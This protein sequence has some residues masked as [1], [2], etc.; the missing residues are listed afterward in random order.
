MKNQGPSDIY[1]KNKLAL[2][3]K[4]H[5]LPAHASQANQDVAEAVKA[6]RC[7]FLAAQPILGKLPLRESNARSYSRKFPFVPVKGKGIVLTDVEGRNY[8]DCLGVAGTLALGYDN[9]IIKDALREFLD[10]GAPLQ[11]LDLAT[12]QKD[13]FMTELL[14]VL[15]KELERLQFCGPAGTDALE[16]AVKIC[17]TKTG[18]S[19]VLS[20]H[21]GYHG[22][23]QGSL[24]MMGNLA[25]KSPI[26]GLMP[27]VHFLPY[28]YSYRN[29]FCIQ[30]EAGEKAVMAYIRTVLTDVESGIP[31]PACVVVEAIQGEGGVNEMSDWALQELRRITKEQDVPLII[32]EVQAGFCRSGHFW[33]FQRSGIVP[34]VLCMSKAVGGGLPQAIVAFRREMDVWS[35]GGHA[36]TF[37]GNQL[38]FV[39]ATAEIK[40]MKEQKLWEKVAKKG[41]HLLAILNK[42]KEE[43]PAIGCVRGRGLMVGVELVNPDAEKDRWGLQPAWGALAAQAQAECFSRGLIIERGGRS[44]CVMRFLVPLIVTEQ[45]LDECVKI[46]GEAIKAA[47]NMLKTSSK[48]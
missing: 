15:P 39:A 42:L 4:G 20:F 34:D 19:T 6:K 33:A 43:Q 3:A 46:F 27:Y 10:S 22:H 16:A 41:E 17:K 2:E 40:Y 11:V 38:A 23:G 31:K 29:P 44:G 9:P 13:A 35:P 45:E 14:S 1:Q 18:R 30:G 32:D 48:A 25:A 8:Y 7:P 26:Q 47:Y 36:G 28:P 37:R 21:G 5:S 24:A 12:P